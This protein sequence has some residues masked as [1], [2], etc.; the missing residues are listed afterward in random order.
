M[1]SIS[2]NKWTEFYSK[3]NDKSWKV[4]FGWITITS[5][6]Y[7]ID[8]LIEN[9]EELLS[10]YEELVKIYE[11]SQKLKNLVEPTDEMPF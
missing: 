9:Y 5:W 10:D 6:R 1:F 8:N 3:R 2:F 7:D 4:C 11:H